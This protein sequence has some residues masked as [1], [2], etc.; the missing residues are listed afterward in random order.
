M[1]KKILIAVGILGIFLLSAFLIGWN[2]QKTSEKEIVATGTIKYIPLEGGFYGIETDKGEKYFPL[3]LSE[4]FKK[5]GLR[6]WLKAKPKKVAT[7]Q[8]WGKPIEILE[9][10]LTE[11][12]NLSQIKVAILYERIT[13]GIYHPSKISTYKDLVNILNETN[14]DLVFRVWWRWTPTPESLPSNSPVY[15]AGHTYQQLEETLRKLKKDLPEIKCWFGA[16]PTQRI[17]FEEKNPITGKIYSQNETWQMALDP[18]K[19][20]IN[21]SKEKLQ[22]LAQEKGGTGKYGYFPDITNKE[23]QELY[24]S[25][26]KRQ[27]DAGVNGLF[28]DML[29][30][31]PRILAKITKNPEHPAVKDSLEAIDYLIKEI[32]DYGKKKGEYIYLCSF[33]TFTDFPDYTPDLDFVLVTPT[34]EE[35]RN[36]A[37]DEERW[38]EIVSKIKERLPKAKILAMIDWAGTTNTP[39]GV[40]SQE[41]SK[42][43]QR[44]F[45]KIADEFF[46]K[47]G[48]IFVYPVH[49]GFMGQD[50][51]ILSFGKLKTYDSLAPEFETYAIIKMLAQSKKAK[52]KL[53]FSDWINEPLFEMIQLSKKRILT[54]KEQEEML[55]LLAEMGIKTVYLTPIWEICEN[56]GG[57]KRYCIKDYYK[58][59]P[60]K[61]TEEDLKEFVEKA[62]SYGMKVILDL[63]TAHT[64]PGRYIY[65]KHKDWIL[66][67]KYGDLVYCWPHKQWGYAVD[68]ANPE[69]I[70]HFT[71][72]AKYY[73]D[74][75]GIDGWRV[76]AIGTV[77]CDETIPDCSQP[78][79]GE[80]HSKDLLKSIK[81]TL[82]KDKALYLEW[83]YLGRL[84]LYNA[85]VEESGGCP[86]PNP[87]P[88]SMA[89]PE[90]NEYADASYSYEFGKCF[91][92]KILAGKITSKDFVDFF[93]KEC[94]YYGKPRGR[95][96]MTHDFGYQFYEKNPELHKLG[97]V[98]ITTIPGF[99][100]IYHRE[101]FPEG[102]INPINQEMFNFYKK[103]LKIREKYKALKYGSISNVWKD[104]DNVIA[105]LR[106]YEDE[107]VIVVINFLNKT[108]VSTL[109]LSV[110]TKGTVLYD[111][112]NNE[113]FVVDE[114]SDFK[115][116]VPAY[117]SRILVLRWH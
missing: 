62:H 72:I 73:V 67:D 33:G 105:Y 110:L 117:G 51:K 101:I 90:L 52:S 1:N 48:I 80:H 29:F 108:A 26:A 27:I 38:D 32:R 107:K 2:F 78:V 91:M 17:N 89:L 70:E 109:N 58:I 53:I 19:W 8:M 83:C 82:G 36:L 35:V 114:P 16:I 111:E 4:E 10:K 37:L 77:Y 94:L 75:F 12:Q 25:W 24:L 11:V 5:E 84:Y 18:Q 54:F 116:S 15:Q 39:L 30:A 50:A 31:Q 79:E 42:E 3:N 6:V 49:G 47:K 100:H 64:G 55:P 113:E 14:P 103:L 46:S 66:K 99:P 112:L 56:P 96:L 106:S 93:K 22:E 7:I 65:E 68:R 59:D 98:L 115:I 87:I 20:G 85:G 34:A 9:I 44:E 45:L 71:R 60:A 43:K 88:C 69:I 92:E 13:D 97:A 102:D 41:L 81:S 40:F 104:G 76:D 21:F 23:F 63:V 28:L 74:E 86:Y 95:F 57:L 61:G